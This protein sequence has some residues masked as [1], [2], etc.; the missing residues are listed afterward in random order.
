MDGFLRLTQAAQIVG[1][2]VKTLRRAM[3][4]LEHPLPVYRIGR[5]LLIIAET[6]LMRWLE[7]RRVIALPTTVE[8]E[9]RSFLADLLQPSSN[10][11]RQSCK[12]HQNDKR[13]AAPR[14]GTSAT[15]GV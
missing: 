7:S 13:S 15:D 2:S 4:D 8:P 12:R 14:S 11:V 5:R 3:R 10:A 1:C 9:V 6:D